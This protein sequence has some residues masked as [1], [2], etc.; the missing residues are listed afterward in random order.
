MKITIARLRSGTNY[1]EPLHDIMDSFYE[2]YKRYM[3]KNPQH[4]YGVYNFGWGKRNRK[5]L[6]DVWDSDVI[7]I[8]SENEFQQHIKGYID[9]RHKER[10]DE[11]VR[12]I[13]NVL[14]DKHVII[15]RSD[16]A[17]NEELYRNKTFKD[18][19]IGKF[20]ILDEMDIPG[21]LHGMKYHFI[22]DIPKTLDEFASAPKTLYDFVYWG[23]DK[24]KTVEN[25]DSG[26]QRHLVF[27]RIRKDK[28]LT[29]FFIGKY[30][31]IE[32]D[33]KINRM[34]HIIPYI[35]KGMATMCFNWMDQTATTSRYHE[36]LGCGLIPFVWQDYDR[37]NTLVADK[38]QRVSSVEEL[39]EK[40][41]ELKIAKG[42][43][44][45]QKKMDIEEHYKSVLKTKDEY[46]ELF[47]EKLDKLLKL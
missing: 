24:R 41:E 47:S 29:S 15:L 37:N 20:S 40:Y 25:V 1:K 28:I 46:F 18:Q 45:G 30:A 38:W 16:R 42:D 10:S 44:L 36:A 23:C 12:K 7:I 17:D 6:D 9:P 14:S 13:G 34:A 35:K 33:M 4:T 32:R 2:L 22:K 39:Y 43:L 19:P 21:G 11:F 8:P 27:K 3:E 31:N 26:D 5:I